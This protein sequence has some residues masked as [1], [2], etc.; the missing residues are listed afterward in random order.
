MQDY[1]AP[2]DNKEFIPFPGYKWKL[3]VPSTKPVPL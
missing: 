3:S 2:N 1:F